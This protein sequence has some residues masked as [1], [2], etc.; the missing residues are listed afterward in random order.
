MAIAEG[1][2]IFASK[3]LND[4]GGA[5]LR[6]FD[7][8]A[9]I[10]AFLQAKA[11]AES[12]RDWQF[13][14]ATAANL[15]SLYL[16]QGNLDA[17]EHAAAQGLKAAGNSDPNGYRSP[18]LL[19]VALLRWEQDK[20]PE[21]IGYFSEAIEAG[22]AKNNQ[23]AVARAW[24]FLGDR[25]LDSA[26]L[27]GAEGPIAEGF[28]LRRLFHD[29]SLSSSYFNL[30]WLRLAQGDPESAANL[31]DQVTS[32]GIN[33]AGIPVWRLGWLR[34]KILEAQNRPDEALHQFE[35]AADAWQSSGDKLAPADEHRSSL[36]SYRT[37]KAVFTSLIEASLA[38][39]PKPNVQAFVAAEEYRAV[40]IQQ[41]F[42]QSPGWR[43]RLDPRYW[44][45][46]N[47]LREAQVASL[48]RNT[49]NSNLERLQQTLT[50][51]EVRAGI[52]LSRTRRNKTNEKSGPTE[53]LRDIQ[54]TLG[55]GE[56][57]LSFY[58]GN[59]VSALWAI[60]DK[61]IEFHRLQSQQVLW[62]IAVNFRQLVEKGSP[63][64]DSIGE[65][66]YNR[67]FRDI[68]PE[69]EQKPF[70]LVA[71][72][73]ELF[74]TPLAALVAARNGGKPVYLVEKH[75]TERIPSA[76]MLRSSPAPTNNGSFLGVADGIYNVADP[77]W[78]PG[79]K[80]ASATARFFGIP[81]P[82]RKRPAV[83]LARLMGSS[84]EITACARIWQGSQPPLLLT[85]SQAS[86]AVFQSDLRNRPAV[87]HLA[88][89]VLSGKNEPKD[90]LIDFGLS[91]EGQPEVLSYTD[92]ANLDVHGA[93]VVVNGCT[94]AEGRANFGAG[95]MGLTRAWLMAGAQ[96]VV[97]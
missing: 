11:I 5:E 95:A 88:A 71:S 62:E 67:L 44:Q 91:P 45:V 52:S 29:P 21:A 70:W 94:S 86:R 12:Q 36:A 49:E 80:P 60:T 97:G 32:K 68:S 42:A 27:A 9:A 8:Q 92:V 33:A 31:L 15:A 24:D 22:R 76:L 39:N 19:T 89:H 59:P 50:E 7:Y 13:F 82:G 37:V 69:I 43:K 73:D 85:G 34:G 28:R 78:R 40:A 58:L 55:P 16:Q 18:L 35:K 77:R 10:D 2:L 61:K 63:E 93:T 87:I 81:V 20:R 23:N 84:Q 46:L 26:D 66:L 83:E 30:S 51:Y 1:D 14:S 65:E 74:D 41:N 56:A 53:T 96:T 64:R 79:W 17:A 25:R 38:R 57:L 4:L 72:A 90:A 54:H 48:D 6:M 47:E 3:F 75:A